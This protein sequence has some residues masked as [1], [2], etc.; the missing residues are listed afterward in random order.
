METVKGDV[1][2]K[3]YSFPRWDMRTEENLLAGLWKG[4]QT[5]WALW[6]GSW[7]W[8][9]RCGPLIIS[10]FTDKTG[11][12][13]T[14]QMRWDKT[15]TRTWASSSLVSASVGAIGAGCSDTQVWAQ[16]PQV[17]S[18][19][20][21]Y[22][23]QGSRLKKGPN[24]MSTLLISSPLISPLSTSCL[25]HSGYLAGF[26]SGRLRSHAQCCLLISTN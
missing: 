24:H 19:C 21:C 22:L 20:H 5:V 13:L 1:M 11:M 14:Q 2:S 10:C 15:R 7:R 4:W 16:A 9:L 12:L 26:S 25:H 23:Y 17:V 8:G 6:G 18:Q 3:N